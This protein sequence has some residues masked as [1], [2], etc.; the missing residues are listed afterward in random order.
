MTA[1]E[2]IDELRRLEQAATEGPWRHGFN[3]GTGKVGEND[4]GGWIVAM[5]DVAVVVGGHDSWGCKSGFKNEADANLSAASR[6]ALPALL[7]VAAK[8][9]A[10]VGWLNVPD[11]AASVEYAELRAALSRLAEVKQ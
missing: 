5:S 3:D 8:A 7:E 10:Y 2:K 4:D 6:N 9:D 11:S 1:Q